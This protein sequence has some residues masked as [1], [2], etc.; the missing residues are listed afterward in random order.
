MHPAA[1]PVLLFSLGFLPLSLAV[2]GKVPAKGPQLCAIVVGITTF[3]VACWL[4]MGIGLESP[5]YLSAAIVGVAG[6]NFVAAGLPALGA[7]GKSMSAVVFWT[8]I[9]LLVT[10]GWVIA[11]VPTLLYTGIAVFIFGILC[12]LGSLPG[13]GV[14]GA[15]FGWLMLLLTI[16]NTL[17]G[18][19]L[20]LGYVS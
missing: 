4:Y 20:A 3:L 8:A 9:M 13:L 1:L 15:S 16:V 5:D 6:V 12:I 11:S 18:Y 14:G 2:A 10:G 19:G 17:I 7:D